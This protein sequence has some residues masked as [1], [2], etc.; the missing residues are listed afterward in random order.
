MERPSS[1]PERDNSLGKRYERQ[2]RLRIAMML[3]STDPAAP[4]DGV[5]PLRGVC[6]DIRWYPWSRRESDGWATSFAGGVT[7]GV[8]HS[9][10]SRSGVPEWADAAFREQKSTRPQPRV[11]DGC[12]WRCSVPLLGLPQ[13]ITARRFPFASA[14]VA[15][16]CGGQ[17]VTP[18]VRRWVHARRSDSLSDLGVD[19][20]RFTVVPTARRAQTGNAERVR[21]E[22]GIRLKDACA[23]VG[24]PKTQRDMFC[25]RRSRL[26][27]ME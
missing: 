26:V 3:E 24:T 19:A 2:P 5:P 6:A 20:S 10:A 7:P 12:L 15:L 9:P 17:C 13:V 23:C 16:L 22:F 4:G 11:H 1:I 27:V 14:A 8:P 18:I 25:S 21:A